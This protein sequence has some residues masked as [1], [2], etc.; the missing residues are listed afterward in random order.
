MASPIYPFVAIVGQTALRASLCLVAADPRIGG[1]LLFGRRG[2]SKSTAVRGFAELLPEI[3]APEGCPIQCLPGEPLGLCRAC[4]NGGRPRPARVRAPLVTLP[5]GAAEDSV[6]GS[7]DIGRAL[8]EGVRAFE[9]GCLGRAHRGV[10]YIDEVNLL[11]DHLVDL[12]LDAAASGTN[13]V[14][15]EG[16]SVTHPASFLLVGSGNPQEGEI[17]PQLLDRFGLSVRV[18][19]LAREDDRVE[20]ARRRIAFDQDPGA[21]DLSWRGRSAELRERIAAARARIE[22]VALPDSGLST[23]ARVAARLA[24]EGHRGEIA[25]ARAARALAALLG[26]AEV[27]LP[28]LAA[29]AA[30]ALAHRL[31]QDVLDPQPA[32]DRLAEAVEEALAFPGGGDLLSRSLGE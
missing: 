9:A 14:E 15:R 6:T 18:E 1:L 20:V 26:E 7:L 32:L 13:V 31:P 28:H 17:R 19:T 30:L 2:T 29:T 25:W 3:E 27:G 10:L 16:V 5:L 12:L 23:V 11:E 24:L 4:E 22:K 21:F 8:A